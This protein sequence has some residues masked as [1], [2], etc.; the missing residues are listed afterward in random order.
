MSLE[1][2]N[3]CIDSIPLRI[4][5]SRKQFPV[6]DIPLNNTNKIPTANFLRNCQEFVAI[7]V[8]LRRNY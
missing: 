7:D 8:N 4:S 5:Y 6:F 2:A 1:L 3:M